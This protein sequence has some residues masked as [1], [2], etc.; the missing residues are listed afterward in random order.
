MGVAVGIAI[1]IV[2]T[3][4]S[5]IERRLNRLSR[6]DAKLDT[7]LKNAGIAFDELHDLPPDVR[8]ALE[9]GERIEAIRRF[10]QATGGG[11]K[12]AKDAIDEARR[13]RS[14]ASS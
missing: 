8:E 11:L 12:E 14:A 9:R 10:R 4:L 1:A 7:L 3:R 6:I 13:R 5:S 2:F